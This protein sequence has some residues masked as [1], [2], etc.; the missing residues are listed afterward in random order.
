MSVLDIF[1]ARIQSFIVKIWLEE[2]A[3]ADRPARWRGS[4]THIP[5][6]KR[7]YFQNL[8]EIQATLVPY[9]EGMG[10][11]MSAKK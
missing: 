7:R 2:T 9:M 3:Q 4:L 1:E 10:L 11:D 6:G 5:S 8:D